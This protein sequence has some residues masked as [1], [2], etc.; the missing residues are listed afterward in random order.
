MG[1]GGAVYQNHDAVCLETQFPP[2]AVHHRNFPQCVLRPGET[3]TAETYIV[4]KLRLE[5]EGC[6]LVYSKV[7]RNL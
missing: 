6:A 2:D 5:A 7:C 3:W 4:S 1:K